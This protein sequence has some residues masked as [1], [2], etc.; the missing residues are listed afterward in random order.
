MTIEGDSKDYDLL[1]SWSERVA[2]HSKRKIMLTAEVGMRKG[3]GTKLILNYIRPNYS[4]LHFHVS[5][6]PYGDL[7]YE[8]YDKTKPSKMDYNEKM[9]AEVKKDFA[10]EPRFN[11]L[12]ITD[13]VFME[14][15]YYGVE[16]YW[17][18]KEYLLNEYSLVHFDGPHKTTDVINEAVFFAERAAPGA[19][20]IFDDWQTYDC[21]IVRDVLNRYEF[22]FC[23]NGSRKMIVQKQDEKIN[24]KNN[25]KT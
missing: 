14:K 1:A 15:Y 2:K 10:G 11:L 21:N 9:F 23:S 5:I 12:N 25:S 18:S 13:R 20:F 17:D 7:V 19:V 22:E 24:N 8:H 16:F 3:L 4:G 6:D